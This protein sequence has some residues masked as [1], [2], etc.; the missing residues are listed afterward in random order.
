MTKQNDENFF[1]LHFYGSYSENI[2]NNNE[3]E[4]ILSN[5]SEGV[6][7]K[8]Q[9]IKKIFI[10]NG[11]TQKNTKNSRENNS[12]SY[13]RSMRDTQNI[14]ITVDQNRGFNIWDYFL[15]STIFNNHS[16]TQPIII[17]N[18]PITRSSN[19]FNQNE[20]DTSNKNNAINKLLFLIS[21]CIITHLMVCAAYNLYFKEEAEKGDKPIDYLANRQRDISIFQLLFGSASFIIAGISITDNSIF[22]PF[23]INTFICLCSSVIFYCA[24]NKTNTNEV[25]PYIKLVELMI[26]NDLNPP[27]Y[28]E[29]VNNPTAPTNPNTEFINPNAK[30]THANYP[31]CTDL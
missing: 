2:K 31:P 12:S 9:K 13:S 19:S 10:Q 20:K 11:I 1:N 27:P 3:I 21:L 30:A 17:N 23:L 24:H 14:R 16:Q 4:A 26:K 5:K 22:I 8:A 25:E 6:K 7:D 28:N 15:L 18:G 29:S